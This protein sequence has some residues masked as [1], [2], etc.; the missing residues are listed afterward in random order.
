MSDEP[1]D[2]PHDDIIEPT[3][4]EKPPPQANGE[5]TITDSVRKSREMIPVGDRG[6]APTS[7]AQWIDVA[8]AMAKATSMLPAHLHN[9]PA[10]LAGIIEIASRFK[11][12]AYML[13]NQTYMPPGGKQLAFQAQAFGAMLYASGLLLGRLHFE[14]SKGDNPDDMTCTVSGRFKDDPNTIHSATTPTL[15]QVRPPRNADGIVKGSPLYDKDPEQQ[16]AYFGERRWIRRYAPDVCMGMYTPE[17]IVEIDDYRV[18][19]HGAIPLSV[20]RLGQ[21]DTGE[22]WGRGDHLDLDL[23][24]I[25][26]EPRPE[27][28]AEPEPPKATGKAP[29]KARKGAA[30]A[31]RAK[32][33]PVVKAR[34]AAAVA[35]RRRPLARPP[36]AMEVRRTADR[37]KVAR[38]A[39]ASDVLWPGYVEKLEQWIGEVTAETAETALAV[40][41]D[42]REARDKARVPIGERSRLRAMLER[43]VAALQPKDDV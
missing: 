32:T 12:S 39:G 28:P 8:K 22:G 30:V 24:A 1:L 23:A 35:P 27:P 4:V 16:L 37:A 11:L 21:L 40:W 26:P 42:G 3:R 31:G 14:F 34:P 18:G 29:G 2:V 33:A 17:E 43:K 41:E 6:L 7:F 38:P 5:E 10:V 25:E 36:T 9:N 13:A 19:Q 20:D 15:K